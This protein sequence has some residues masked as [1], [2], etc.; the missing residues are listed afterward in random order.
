VVAIETDVFKLVEF[1]AEVAL[2]LGAVASRAS[3]E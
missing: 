1:I 2:F 3:G